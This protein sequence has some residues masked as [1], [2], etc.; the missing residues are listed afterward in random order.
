MDSTT[1]APTPPPSYISF[2]GGRRLAAGGLASVALS[3]AQALRSGAQGPVL[4]FDS[5]SGAVVDIDTRGSD[6]EVAARYDTPAVAGTAAAMAEVPVVRGRG[7][8]KLGV[9]AREVT[10][11][12][13]HWEWLATQSG[14]A[15][16]T[17]RK[18]IDE[19]RRAQA[20]KGETRLR[21]ERAYRFMSAIAGDYAGFEEASRALF[22]GDSAR[23]AEHTRS[24]PADVRAFAMQL[25]FGSE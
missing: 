17:L 2:D 12:P 11:L 8:P 14:G 21:R 18:L 7:R 13:R 5:H 20:A 6:A 15:S 10:L 22:A 16:V 24:W 25:A 3:V 9:V 23:F 19:A 1:A 4:A